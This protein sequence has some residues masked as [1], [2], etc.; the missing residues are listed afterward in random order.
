MS[1]SYKTIGLLD[2]MGFGNMGDAAVQ[3]AFITNIRRRVPSARL[4]AFSLFPDDTQKRHN[5]TAFPIKWC[6]PALR[7]EER[8]VERV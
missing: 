6:Y 8:R 3:E 1:T 5:V 7:S 2:H 4:I